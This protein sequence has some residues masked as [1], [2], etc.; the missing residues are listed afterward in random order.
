MRGV[1]ADHGEGDGVLAPKPHVLE[2]ERAT[3]GENWFR[4]EY[5]CEFLEWE[6]G[7][8]STGGY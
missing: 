4:Q 3:L 1:G 5:L 6:G 8:V 7:R 2:E